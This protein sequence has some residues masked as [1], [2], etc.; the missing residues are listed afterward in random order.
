MHKTF[1]KF[2]FLSLLFSPYSLISQE[3]GNSYT[4]FGTIPERAPDSL[5]QQLDNAITFTDRTFLIETIAQV[6]IQLGNTDSIIY[7]GN[8]LK[9]EV[10]KNTPEKI[11]NTLLLSKSYEILGI[12]SFQKGLYDE[13]MKYY[14]QGISI[15]PKAKNA[16]LHYK[17]KLGLA[18]AY[19]EKGEYDKSISILDECLNQS[20]DKQIRAFANKYYGDVYLYGNDLEASKMFYKKA[21]KDFNYLKLD[22]PI[23][24]VQINLGTIALMEKNYDKALNFLGKAK[25]LA[26]EKQF[27]DLYIASILRIGK[28]YS[29]TKQY[30]AAQIV[31]STAYVNAVQWNQLESQ[32]VIAN[33]LIDVYVSLEDYKNA[34][35]LMTQYQSISNMITQDQN[36]KEVKELEIKYQTVQKENEILSLQEEQLLKESE[37]KRQKTIKNAFLIGFLILLVPIVALL[38]VYYQKLQAQSQ[39]NTKQEEINRQKV[40]SLIKGQEL[41]LVKASI[42]AQD[43]ERSRIARELHDSIGGNLA[44]IKLQMNNLSDTTEIKGSIVNQIDETYKQVREISHNLIPSKFSQNAFTTL[45]GEYIDKLDKASDQN[46]TFIPHPESK[47]NALNENLQVEIFNILQELI[48]NTLKHAKAKNIEIHVNVHNN[49]VQMLFEDNGIG[50]DTEKTPNGIGLQNIK[51]RLETLNAQ[52]NIDSVLNR[53]TVV[54]IEIPINYDS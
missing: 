54:N 52:I 4:A 25:N 24:K 11:T 37:I 10:L 2:I 5:Y 40:S 31:L 47:I 36:T 50:Y 45:I 42:E 18:L 29:I 14:L 51:S 23:L 39:L 6:H 7:Y 17:H 30:E 22:K 19:I 33:N 48:T 20:N 38:Y 13:A 12:G 3:N 35:S 34:Y 53:G 9:D 1:Y 43:D 8:Y 44:A 49:M 41:K 16:L 15:T 28:V 32:K 21:L 26:L 27:Y 46:I